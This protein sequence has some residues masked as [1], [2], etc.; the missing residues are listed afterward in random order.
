MCTYSGEKMTPIYILLAIFGLLVAYGMVSFARA[1]SHMRAAR[2]TALYYL[3]APRAAFAAILASGGPTF[4][5][6][7]V[8][9][10]VATLLAFASLVVILIY[11]L[12][13]RR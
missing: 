6:C 11:V 9:G 2:K 7:L 10:V 13:T 1:G 5:R 4:R 12:V 3:K 8:R